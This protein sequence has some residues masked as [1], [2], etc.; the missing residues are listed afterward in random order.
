MR[1]WA[2]E[3]AKEVAGDVQGQ[4]KKVAARVEGKADQVA[5][6]AKGKA[7]QVAGQAKGKADQVAGQAK[8]KADQV[9]GQAKGKADQVAGEAKSAAASA[10]KKTPDSV[11]EAANEAAKKVGGKRSFE[12]SLRHVLFRNNQH[13]QIFPV[14]LLM[15]RATRHKSWHY[16]VFD[17]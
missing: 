17:Q 13:F 16:H 1:T 14:R 9:G 8:D 15:C 4:A 2:Q 7:D 11:D 10:D 3:K 5:S 12:P 6:Q